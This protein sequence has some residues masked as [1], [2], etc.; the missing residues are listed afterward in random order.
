MSSNKLMHVAPILGLSPARVS[1]MQLTKFDQL[2]FD[3]SGLADTSA[4]AGTRAAVHGSWVW[5]AG[6]SFCPKCV[7]EDG[8]A[9]RMNWRVP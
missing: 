8:G 6:S 1:E 5:L 3:L 7:A 9:W 2:A 4:I